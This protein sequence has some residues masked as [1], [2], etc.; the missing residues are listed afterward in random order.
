MLMFGDLGHDDPNK[1]RQ[2]TFGILT[3][4]VRNSAGDVTKGA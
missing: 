1:V 4:Q 2:Q 3:G